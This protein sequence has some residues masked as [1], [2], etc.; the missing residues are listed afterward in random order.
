MFAEPSGIVIP[1]ELRTAISAAGRDVPV[2]VGP[3][4]LLLNGSEREMLFGEGLGHITA[5]QITQADVVAITKIDSALDTEI[6]RVEKEVA[7]LAPQTDPHHVSM[8]SGEGVAAL[9]ES[10]LGPMS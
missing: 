10:I 2:T 3:V 4:V 8:Q 9:V 7:R 1:F 5:Q 6:L